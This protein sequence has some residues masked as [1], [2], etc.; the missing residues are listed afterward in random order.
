MRI[1]VHVAQLTGGQVEWRSVMA[2]AWTRSFAGVPARKP[3]RASSLDSLAFPELPRLTYRQSDSLRR[4]HVDHV[5][6][7]RR[8][9]DAKVRGL[10]TLENLRAVVARAAGHF[11]EAW[12]A[13]HESAILA[14]A[15]FPLMGGTRAHAAGA[16]I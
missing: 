5:L 14:Y 10:R 1:I 6:E 15:P 13:G 16:A 8:L 4:L 7:F 9:L 2:L 12:T 11:P 3:G